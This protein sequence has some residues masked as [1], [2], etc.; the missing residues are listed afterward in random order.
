M[1]LASLVGQTHKNWECLVVD[2]GS[3]DAPKAV[4]DSYDDCRIRFY[5]F[6]ENRGRAI[7]RQF[8]LTEAKGEFLAF[9]DA[10]DW[11][12]PEKLERQVAV[13]GHFSNVDIV[14]TA[15]SVVDK[16][17]SYVAQTGTG[18]AEKPTTFGIMKQLVRPPFPLVSS[19]IRMEVARRGRYNP[20]FSR[21]QDL[22]FMLQVGIGREWALMD[23]PY[24][25]Y[26]GWADPSLAKHS[27]SL[28]FDAKS[29]WSYR[30]HWPVRASWLAALA[31]S[32]KLIYHVAYA[33][34]VEHRIIARRM[35]NPANQ[36]EIDAFEAIRDGIMHSYCGGPILAKPGT[37]RTREPEDE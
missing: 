11:L 22:D 26:T 29:Y 1:A 15:L 18:T 9:L 17:G 25:V 35:R 36:I 12:F 37:A 7:V 3:T 10:D 32:K 30:R 19:M 8:A 34:R 14:S 20:E 24:Y 23:E 33:A 6:D 27:Q 21:A 13:L 4:V 31:L 5:R 28:T 2:D 16:D